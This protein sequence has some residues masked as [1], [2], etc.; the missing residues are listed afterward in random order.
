MGDPHFVSG[1]ADYERNMLNQSTVDEIRA[2]ISD[3][4]TL[5]ISDYDPA[6]IESLNT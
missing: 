4:H 1:M 5:N 6:G 3:T 2:K